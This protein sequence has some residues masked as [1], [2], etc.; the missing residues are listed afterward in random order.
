M[1][2]WWLIRGL[3]V[4]V[5]VAL[6]ITAIG[7]VVMSLWNWLLPPLVGWHILSF[8]QALGLLLLCRILFG[9]IRGHRGGWK[10]RMRERWESMTPEERERVRSG[11][12]RG[13]YCRQQ[14]PENPQ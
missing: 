11:V 12:R 4:I 13:S 10:H 6:A 3:K 2:R 7:F 9:G 14:M 8:T 5:L 1:K